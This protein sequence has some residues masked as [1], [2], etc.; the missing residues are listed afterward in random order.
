MI[1]EKIFKAQQTVPRS[2]EEVFDFFSKA[3]NLQRITPPLLNFQILTPM[4]IEMKA[5]A[6]IDYRLKVRGLPMIWRTRIE[7]W[8]PP[9]SFVDTQLKGPYKLWHHTHEFKSLGPHETLMTDTVRYQVP[10]GLL[11]L[12]AEALIVRGD[13]KNIFAFRE[14]EIARI[15]PPH[16]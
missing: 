2:I 1:F 13:I 15:F 3:E 10:L 11:G 7:S 14:S 9:F 8:Q 6:L 12:L 4:P 5:G 16:S